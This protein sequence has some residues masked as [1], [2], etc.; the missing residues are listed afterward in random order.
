[1]TQISMFDIGIVCWQFISYDPPPPHIPTEDFEN[2]DESCRAYHSRLNQYCHWSLLYSQGKLNAH[3]DRTAMEGVLPDD[4]NNAYELVQ[5]HIMARHGDRSPS[6]PYVVGSSVFYECGLVE[7]RRESSWKRLQDFPPLKGLLHENDRLYSTHM[8]LYPGYY[9]KQ[10]GI[11]KLTSQGFHQ[12]KALGM[13]MSRKYSK[14]L[15]G[16][17]T[18]HRLARSIF[19][20]STDVPRTIQ[21]AAAFMLGFLPDQQRL[22][23]LVTIHVSP[24]MK[25]QAPPPGISQVFKPC[26]NFPLFRKRELESTDFF[27]TEKEK[28]HPL[29]E[30]F[31]HKFGLHNVQNSP[32]I[33]KIF[34][35]IWTRGCHTQESPLP[36]YNDHCLD[37]NSAKRMYESAD[38]AFTN[39]RT[40]DSSLLVMIPFFR[41]S[42]LG[43]MEGAVSEN[44]DFKKFVL[45]LSHDSTMT[46]VLI[47]L[48][49]RLDKWMPYASRITFE[50]W[51]N[52]TGVGVRE[53]KY[54]VRVLFNGVPITH[55][56]SSLQRTNSDH[57]ELL[58]YSAWKSFTENGKYRNTQS[59]D[60]ACGN[61]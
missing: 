4:L 20:Q 31:C 55:E 25:L 54:H 38:W 6:T 49:M 28:Y 22:R 52:K 47:A 15:F 2:C 27:E 3:F 12:H 24:G 21:S 40:K 46:R 14:L 58:S 1:M 50:L 60:Q 7:M 23:K 10:C 56:L 33:T 29:L 44:K 16:N 42:V 19:I 45:S 9:S 41:H 48:G 43:L 57:P 59:Y 13:Q 53:N 26:K 18:H 37:Y 11:G 36:C 39:I 30:D 61:L 5:V 51:K 17:S 32:I 8:T 35:S 34:D